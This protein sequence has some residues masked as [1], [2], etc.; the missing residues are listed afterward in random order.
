MKVTLE[1]EGQTD[2][3]VCV[4]GN[5]SSQD[6]FEPCLDSGTIIE[7]TES[8]QWLQELILCLKCERI[9]NQVTLDII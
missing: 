8:G 5:K 9:I 6:G 1:I 3:L 2:T 7:A 4:C